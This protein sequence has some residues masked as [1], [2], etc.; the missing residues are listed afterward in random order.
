M[1]GWRDMETENSFGEFGFEVVSDVIV[2]K[3]IKEEHQVQ[4]WVSGGF[5]KRGT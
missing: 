1:N 4:P 2:S 5:L 3:N